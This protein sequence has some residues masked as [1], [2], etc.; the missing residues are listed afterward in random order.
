MTDDH[1]KHVHEWEWEWYLPLPTCKNKDCDKVLL[2]EDLL[3]MLNAAEQL[4]HKQ[5]EPKTGPKHGEQVMVQL[6]GKTFRCGCGCNVFTR[7][8][9]TSSFLCNA[10]KSQW[11]GEPYTAYAKARGGE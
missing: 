10:C 2:R 5:Q 9:D 8:R 4:K 7:I 6:E 11:K 1:D 3:D